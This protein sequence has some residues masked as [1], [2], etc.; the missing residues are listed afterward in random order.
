MKTVYGPVPSWRF[1]RSLG[2]DTTTLPK[3]CTF[4]CIYCQLGRTKIHV[5]DPGK[6]NEDLP[7]PGRIIDEFN[8]FLTG[9]DID[10]IDV[11]TFSGT[12]EPTLNLKLGEIIDGIRPL[13]GSIPLVIL[14]NASQLHRSDVAENVS[15]LDIITNKFD[16]GDE[17]TF[18]AIN[19]PV[20]GISIQK[21][22]QSIKSLKAKTEGMV[23]LEVMLLRTTSGISNV[24][25]EARRQLINSIIDINPDLVQVYTPWRPP[26]EGFV[27]PVSQND[28]SQF[29]NDLK[30][31]LGEE[32][33]WVYGIHD[34]RGKRVEWKPG[35]N[36]KDEI[37]EILKRRPCRVVDISSMLS[38]SPTTVIKHMT[39]LR[40]K[41]LIISK[42]S[43]DETYYSFKS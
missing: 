27:R 41:D 7:T 28:L 23:A 30:G 11:V 43:Q 6:V 36:L 26:S 31:T 35:K 40:S 10:T 2:I 33:L 34:A 13:V 22:K 19:R 1:G 3:K 42:V 37:L 18:R 20:R 17:K 12:G 4:D 21:I 14:T 25:G 29:A 9:I 8:Q 32:K 15:R 24:D 38:L 5:S 16:A 39:R